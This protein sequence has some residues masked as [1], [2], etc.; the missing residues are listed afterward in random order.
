M[1]AEQQQAKQRGDDGLDRGGDPEDP[2]GDSELKAA[3]DMIRRGASIDPRK[4]A[5]EDADLR[6]LAG[7]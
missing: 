4:L 6:V 7:S 2:K 3:V 5:D 1:L